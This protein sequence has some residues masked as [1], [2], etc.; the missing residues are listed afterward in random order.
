MM[1]EYIVT[2]TST[3]THTIWAESVDEA[4]ATYMMEKREGHNHIV[5]TDETVNFSLQY[6]SEDE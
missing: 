1:N 3:S 2:V 6:S 5:E 4:M